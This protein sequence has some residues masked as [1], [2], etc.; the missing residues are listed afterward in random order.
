MTVTLYTPHSYK[1]TEAVAEKDRRPRRVP[2][3][4]PTREQT[5]EK[6]RE[7]ESASPEGKVKLPPSAREGGVPFFKS[8]RR[9]K[10][11]PPVTP[12]RA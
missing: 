2:D 1:G 11:V 9:G 7:I 3:T 4:V 12:E 5:G 10:S 8:R 6:G